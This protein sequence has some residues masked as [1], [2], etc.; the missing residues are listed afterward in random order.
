VHETGVV[1]LLVAAAVIAGIAALAVPASAKG[2]VHPA[3]F[4]DVA[5]LAEMKQKAGT[6]DWA[7][8]VVEGLDAG[9]QPWLE[10]PLD[11]IEELMPKQKTQV[12]WLMTCPECRGGL[13]FDPFNDQEATCIQCG[14]TFSLDQ[15]SP[16]TAPTSHY[17]GTLYEGWG[18]SYL[19]TMARTTQQLALLHAL[20]SDR[21]YA[22]RSAALL[23]LFAKHIKPLPVLGGGTQHVIWTY[24]MEGDCSILLGLVGAYEMLRNV[25]GLFTAD[26]H[27]EIQIDLLKHWVDSVFRV[28][29]D[30]SPNHNSMYTYLSASALVGCAIEDA[31]YVDWAFGR[32]KYSPEKRPNHRSL[33]WLADNNYVDDGAFWG[34]CSAYHLY[35]LGPHCRVFVLAHRLSRQM[36][37]L[38]PPEIYDETDPQNPRSRVLRRAIKWFTA[39]TFPDLTM[40]PFG[41]M[42]GRVSLVT[43]ALTAEIGY[44]Y[45]RIDEVG[46]YSSLRAG[47]R[48]LTGLMYG[49]DTIEER[50]VPYQSANLA[51]GYVAL[52]READGNRLYAGL[53]ALIPGSGHSH[54]DRLHLL[55]YSRDRMLT[56]E[57][58]TRYNDPDQRI[59][60]GASYGHNTVTVDET[61]QVHGNFLKD[62]RIPHI[63]TFVDLPAAQVAE[64]HGDKVYENTDIYRRILC[65][66]EEY[67]LDIFRV[68]GG[69]VH[70]WFY[71][72]VGEEPVLSIPMESKT[73]FGPALYV[74]R[75]DPAYKTGAG[76]DTFTA[77][78]RIPAEEASELPGR[79]RDVFSRVTVA[80]VPG[81]KAFALNTFPNPGKHSL[82]VRHNGIAAPFVVV[83]EAYHDGPVATG[84]RLLPGDAVAAVEITHADGGKRLAIYESGSGPDGWELKGRFGAIELDP[85]GRCRSLMLVRGTELRYGDIHFRA[86]REASLSLTFDSEGARLVSSPAVG[87]ETL[88]GMPAY[89]TGEDT[90]VS[91]TVPAQLSPTGKEIRN[92]AIVVPGQ[93]G[94]GPVPVDVPL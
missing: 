15:P 35:A 9:A 27:R 2:W 60:S 3:G 6:L 48:G 61:S 32:R 21:S 39:Q 75:G 4:L 57:K 71:H 37:D 42:G 83:H 94:D 18:C 38:F 10:Q 22:E 66:F 49:V 91:L 41:D 16:A 88:E 40:A 24:N 63:D 84:V 67:L 45:L 58:R 31:D 5:T 55:T 34:L 33:A 76:D 46:S 30:S 23:K 50:P 11:R 78:W 89:A 77:T 64:A 12:Y 1:P 65:Q 53:N 36:P 54:G 80:G 29:E 72:G 28:E 52:K 73:G 26:E 93:T 44:R 25:E 68:Q 79:E 56:G 87:Y 14:K 43:Y 47:T 70:D 20:G 17:A 81:Q 7:R 90:T 92:R 86:D 74:M 85:G 82:M 13:R 69:K 19:Q 51:S 62:E 59:Y 8:R